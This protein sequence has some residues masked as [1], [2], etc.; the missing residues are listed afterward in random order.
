MRSKYLILLIAFLFVAV[1]G[2]YF[3]I[4][5]SYE[6]SLRARYY[7]EVGDYDKAYLLAKEAF[8][9]D[10]YNRMASTIMTQSQ[11]SLKYTTYI[12]DAKSYMQTIDGIAKHNN[13]SEPD[14]AKIKMLCKIML[15]TYIKLAPSAITDEALVEEA[16]MY[17]QKFEIL[18]EKVDKN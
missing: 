5:P 12:E 17:N 8:S 14:K 4:N 16:A 2:I 1:M 9:I 13:I 11:T 18:L 7:Y 6:K 3:F 15:S 10:L